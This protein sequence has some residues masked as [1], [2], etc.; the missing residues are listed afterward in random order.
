MSF[1]VHFDVLAKQPAQEALNLVHSLPKKRLKDLRI[2]DLLYD[3]DEPIYYGVYL[4]YSPD[5]RCLYVGKNSAQKFVERIPWH[6]SIAESSWMNHLVRYIRKHEGLE[7]LSEA[8]EVASDN[9]LL[10]IPFSRS[11]YIGK[12]EGECIGKL[13]KFFRLF[14]EP[15]YNTYS[16]RT[17]QKNRSTIDLDIPLIEVVEQL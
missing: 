6:L 9:E 8:A 7:S 4:F 1:K 2:Y 5:G 15:K 3:G 16:P 13:E 12:L 17:R 11:E 10:L 14:A